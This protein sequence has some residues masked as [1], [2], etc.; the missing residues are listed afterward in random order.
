MPFPSLGDLPDL[1]IK[2]ASPVSL[3][4]QADSLLLSHWGSPTSSLSRIYS[5]LSQPHLH[6]VQPHHGPDQCS[7]SHADFLAPCPQLL[8]FTQGDSPPHLCSLVS[9]P[10]NS[11]VL[12]KS[13]YLFTY[14]WLCW[15]SV[16]VHRLSLVVAR[17][18]LICS[19]S[20][21]C[22]LYGMQASVVT[23]LEYGL[24]CCGTWA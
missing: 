12:T 17:G 4:L 16:A 13:F 14:F 6:L 19:G 2:P 21:C 15:V 5:L 24:L 22:G 9:L 8:P 18:L 11:T 20:S 7:L 23:A 10:V 1:G 3:A